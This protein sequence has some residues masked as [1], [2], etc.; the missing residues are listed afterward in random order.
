MKR[1]GQTHRTWP[2]IAR[3]LA[4]YDRAIFDPGSDVNGAGEATTFQ[5]FSSRIEQIEQACI[6]DLQE[7]G[8][9]FVKTIRFGYLQVTKTN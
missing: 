9:F 5:A 1:A 8:I 3:R 7:N 6:E 2:T 4:A